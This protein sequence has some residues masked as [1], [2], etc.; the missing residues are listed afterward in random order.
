MVINF[1][2][3]G[4]GGGGTTYSAGTN[5][6]ITDNVISCTIDTGATVNA[7]VSAAS[8]YTDTQS[9]ATYDASTAYTDSKSAATYNASTAFTQNYVSQQMDE[10]VMM[11]S[12]ETASK[13][14]LIWAGTAAEYALLHYTG[15]T[16]L[17]IIF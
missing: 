9:A 2:K 12:G 7:A 14:E 6:D 10:V 5:I 3:G 8:A 17:Y 1:N 16:T 13:V 15:A 11:D 4:G